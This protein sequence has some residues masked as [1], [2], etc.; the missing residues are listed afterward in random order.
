MKRRANV[1]LAAVAL[2]VVATVC[3]SVSA[4]AASGIAVPDDRQLTIHSTN[5]VAPGITEDHITTVDKATGTGQVES[6]VATI[7]PVNYSTVGFLASYKDYDSSGKWGLQTVRDQA[8]AASKKISS[9]KKIVVAVNGDY[10]NMTTGEPSGLLVMNEKVVHGPGAEE[11]YFCLTKDGKYDIRYAWEDFSDVKEGVGSPIM[12]IQ[13]GQLT[14]TAE[15]DNHDKMPRAAIGL[16]AEGKIVLYEADGRQV[17]SVGATLNAV[18]RQMKELGCVEAMYLD[19]G[20]S[21]TFTTRAEGEEDLVVRNSP[22]DGMERQVSS[23]LLFYSTAKSEGEFDHAALTPSQ[24]VYTPGSTVAFKAKGVDSAGGPADVPTSAEFA[25]AP[26]SAAL[27]TIDAATGAFTSNGACGQVTC[28]LM[29]EGKVCGSTTVEIQ[30]PDAIEFVNDEVNLGFEVQSDLGLQV[31]YHNR[32]MEYKDGDFTWTIANVSSDAKHEVPSDKVIGTF[33]GNTFTSSDGNTL[34]GTAT[35]SYAKQDGSTVSGSVELIV[36]L[37]PTVV[38]D[39]EDQQAEDGSTIAAKDY[40]TFDKAF[41]NASGGIEYVRDENGNMIYGAS[42]TKRLLTGSYHNGGVGR[43][44]NESAEIISPSDGYPAR[45]GTHALKLSY[46]FTQWNGI[47]EGACFGFSQASQEIPGSPTGIGV[48]CYAPEGAANLWIRCRVVDGAGN[49]ATVNFVD[50]SDPALRSDVHWVGWRYLEADLSNLQGPFSLIGGETVRVMYLKG[51]G[52]KTSTGED[53]PQSQAKG[54]LIFDDLAF[55]YGAN[56][57]DVDNPSVGDIS[58]NGKVLEED[59]VLEAGNLSFAVNVSDVENKYTSGVNFDVSSMNVEL[60]GEDVTTSQI[61][62]GNLAA[63]Q[64]KGTVY[65]YNQKLSNGDHSLKITIRDMNGNEAFKQIGFTVSAE[66]SS[67]AKVK[68][69]LAQ[70]EAELGGCV[71]V[72]AAVDN[73]QNLGSFTGTFKISADYKDYT[74]EYGEGFEQAAD[75]VYSAK[76]NSLTISAKRSEGAANEGQGTVATI[77]FAVPATQKDGDKFSYA[78]TSA[79]YSVVSDQGVDV[80]TF[81]KK[82]SSIPVTARYLIT[83]DTVLAGFNASMTVTDQQ[84]NPVRVDVYNG[85]DVKIGRTDRNGTFTIPAYDEAQ[86]IV[87]Y[88]MDGQGYRSFILNTQAFSNAGNADGTPTFVK[89]NAANGASQKNITW[90]ANPDVANKKAVAQVATKAAYDQ[91]GEDAFQTV[92]GTCTVMKLAGSDVAGNKTAYSNAV[93][94]TDLKQGTEYAYRVGDGKRWSPVYTTSTIWK[95]EDTKFFLLGDTQVE[96]GDLETIKAITDQLGKEDFTFG[97]QLGDFVEQPTVYTY[98]NDILTAFDTDALKSTDMIHVMGNHEQYGD[99]G[100][101]AKSMFN[102][103]EEPYYSVTYGN[104]YV[105]VLEYAAG[106]DELNKI[107]DWLVKDASASKATWKIV[108]M[109]AP[110]Y[111]TNPSEDSYAPINSIIPAA[112]DQ[113]G[114]DFVFSGHNHSYA[115]TVPLV[116]QEEDPKGTVYFTCGS[117]GEKSYAVAPGDFK[118]AKETSE[119]K[120]LPTQ[121]F[122]GLYLTVNATDDSFTVTAYERNGSVYDTYTKEKNPCGEKG[123]DFRFD[124]DSQRLLCANCER[125]KSAGDYTG[126]V[127]TVDG[128]AHVYLV[129]GAMQKNSWAPYGEDQYYVGADGMSVSGTQVIDGIEY[130]F[131]DLGKCIRGS[132][133]KETV[134][135]ADGTTKSLTRYYPGGVGY[136]TGWWDIDDGKYFFHKTTGELYTGKNRKIRAATGSEYRYYTFSST[137]EL[138]VGAFSKNPDTGKVRYYWGDTYVK[139]ETIKVKGA[140]YTFDDEGNM[141]VKKLSSC[142]ISLASKVTYTGKSQKPK[143]TITYGSGTLSSTVTSETVQYNNFTVSY[144]SNVKIGTAKVTLKGNPDRGFTGTVTR[145][146]KICPKG[147]SLTKVSAAKKGFKA[148][149]KKQTTKTTGYLIRYSTSSK[150]TNVKYSRITKNTTTS[151]SVAKLKA[152]TRYYVQ[153]LTYTKVGD[154]NYNS[155]WSK[156]MSVR[157]K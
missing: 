14:A 109:H 113:A 105:A 68:V 70:E 48:W 115:R 140:P 94:L 149:W 55:V 122:D 73:A 83:L 96:T 112:C 148:T 98:W 49:V 93:V 150:M 32:L 10:F 97:A 146:F 99:E 154:T 132:F 7:D 123:H 36:G 156:V 152:N 13:D 4:F 21:A 2:A 147:T 40:W 20:G 53:L 110:P 69:S 104:T 8:K 138:L 66:E 27:G 137:G 131:D 15:W 103:P 121:D 91:S 139:G 102:I 142:K 157:T 88:V 47:T 117:T 17:R 155:S 136:A 126:L 78:V 24:L 51:Y 116:N 95:G 3:L 52:N 100:A 77:R 6:Y 81:V 90:L 128:K 18:A 25:L 143:V 42:A 107:A 87:L 134:T 101:A 111:N 39:F 37:Q 54:Y 43:G 76:S 125:T 26:E 23:A 71:D 9:D 5:K 57:E 74:V 19:G 151:R 108:L 63:D 114:I 79:R 11:A 33:D 59:A 44:G 86:P 120:A 133:V 89:L 82:A 129:G 62:A 28:N 56:V 124:A 16:T 45:K 145:T 12:L 135:A 31:K 119:G 1:K 118:W 30:E 80:K 29:Y 65:L 130:T 144:S 46:D 127:K 35:C 22:S 60:D 64:S 58:A 34:Y 92:E 141:V 84:G 50:N 38:M 106:K 153:V 75:P 61:E 72:V 67:P 41:F 85:E